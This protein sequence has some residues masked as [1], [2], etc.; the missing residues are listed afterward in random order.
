MKIFLIRHGESFWNIDKILMWCRIE[1][2]LT[3]NGIASAIKIAEYF[4]KNEKIDKIFSSP[5]SRARQTAEIISEKIFWNSHEII[6]EKN[7]QEID[8]WDATGF[9]ISEIPDDWN[10]NFLENPY[11]YNYPNGENFANFSFR[12]AEIFDKILAENSW[13]NIIIV[14]HAVCISAM[15]AKI[16]NLTLEVFSLKIENSAIIEYEFDG[17]KFICNNF[18]KKIT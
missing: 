9:K 8:W 4:A 13:K 17:K 10:K 15:I 7:L 12:V 16:R 2:S 18:N 3:E 11:F 6:F 14:S 1:S 5:I